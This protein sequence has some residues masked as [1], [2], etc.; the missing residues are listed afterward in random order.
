MTGNDRL[1]CT[2][3]S[4]TRLPGG[5]GL[6]LLLTLLPAP[7]PLH[8]QSGVP[9]DQIHISITLGGYFLFGV[10]YTHWMETHH[11]L[12]FTVFPFAY[13]GEGFPFG[14]RAGYAWVPSDEVWRAKLGG[15][16]MVLVRPGQTGGDRFTP[17]LNFTPGIQY[18]TDHDRSFRGDLWMSY[19][20]KERVFAPTGIEFLYAW[21]K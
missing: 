7:R 8:G 2:A 10:G 12:E 20:L 15:N 21:P 19:Y 18:D 16:M 1:S 17:I 13:P 9:T 14:L 6:L 3:T 5:L 4:R 11:A